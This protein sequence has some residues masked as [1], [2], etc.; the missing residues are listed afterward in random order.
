MSRLTRATRR[1]AA[2]AGL[3]GACLVPLLAP[4]AASAGGTVTAPKPPS[5][6]AFLAPFA[7]GFD[8]DNDNFNVATHLVLQFPDLVTAATRAGDATV[9]LPTDYAFRRLVKALTGTTVVSEAKLFATVMLLG[10]DRLGQVLRHH[11]IPKARVTYGQLVRGHGRVLRT[12]QGG[13][14]KVVVANVP[15]RV[16]HL[17]DAAPAMTD[18]KVIRA[19]VPM[20]NGVVHVIDQVLLPFVP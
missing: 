3:A 14:L 18:A 19:D 9:F 10:R 4:A 11:V 16:V 15:R 8:I 7:A 12:L 6:A 13:T 1:P 2:I 5:V 20:S 17:R